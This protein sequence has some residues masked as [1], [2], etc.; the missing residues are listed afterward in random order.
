MAIKH[1][2]AKWTPCE[3]AIASWQLKRYGVI[4]VDA[5][6][7]PIADDSIIEALQ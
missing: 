5:Y 4:Y 3:K 6:G 2:N 7:S 1:I